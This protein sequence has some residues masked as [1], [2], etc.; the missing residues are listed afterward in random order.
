MSSTTLTGAADVDRL[1]LGNLS[2]KELSVVC[3]S[4]RTIRNLCEQI[5]VNRISDDIG[6]DALDF[7][8]E[9]LSWRDY[10]F[11]MREYLIP[12]SEDGEE[13]YTETDEE[14]LTRAVENGVLPA[15][16]ILGLRG[17]E[18]NKDLVTKAVTRGYIDLLDLFWDAGTL[19]S[20]TQRELMI[21]IINALAPDQ[22]D[23]VDW[24]EQ[25]GIYLT[26][27]AIGAPRGEKLPTEGYVWTV[28]IN[29][30]RNGDGIRW[31]FDHGYDQSLTDKLIDFAKM[32]PVA[33]GVFREYGYS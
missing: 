5:W 27:S 12:K 2:N 9:D 1:I 21:L 31:L 16:E 33:W 4:N 19:D 32:K 6:A 23:V 25:Q 3:R 22:V 24:F 15:V 17:L 28:V 20:F 10:Y 11:V 13:S 30:T 18:Y 8:P 26:H 7:K 14:L 29:R